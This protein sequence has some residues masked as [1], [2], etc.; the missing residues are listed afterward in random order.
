MEASWKDLTNYYEAHENVNNRLKLKEGF[1]SNLEDKQKF[2]HRTNALNKEFHGIYNDVDKNEAQRYALFRLAWQFRKW[3]VPYW[4]RRYG[5]GMYHAEKGDYQEG[6]YKVVGRFIKQMY[7]EV[8]LG[9]FSLRKN[10]NMLSQQEKANFYKVMS[11]VGHILGF[12]VLAAL[13][14]AG[15]DDDEDNWW[16]QMG[17]YQANRAVTELGAMSLPWGI[18]RKD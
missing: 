17:A 2:I 14:T 15:A 12:M 9:E 1:K 5:K 16:L 18:Y 13:L 10:W 7:T 11:E 8:K 4:N 6:F 3:M